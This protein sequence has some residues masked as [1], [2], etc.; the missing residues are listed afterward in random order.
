MLLNSAARMSIVRGQKQSHKM[1]SS[2]IYTEQPDI[3]ISNFPYSLRNLYF[4]WWL[5]V[6]WPCASIIGR[7]L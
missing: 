5:Y 4:I 3:N 1:F 2:N 6:Y 7:I